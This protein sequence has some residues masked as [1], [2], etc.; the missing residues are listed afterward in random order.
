ML[1]YG[2]V[3]SQHLPQ[4]VLNRNGTDAASQMKRTGRLTWH[5][6]LPPPIM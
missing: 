6:H 1:T 3:Q 4:I 5:T 2:I